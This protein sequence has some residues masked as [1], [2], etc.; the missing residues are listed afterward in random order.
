MYLKIVFYHRILLSNNLFGELSGMSEK[1]SERVGECFS[2]V[3]IM[4]FGEGICQVKKEGIT[5]ELQ[6]LLCNS[7]EL[8]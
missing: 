8:Q 7:W 3:V 2:Q 5:S 6:G 4:E 1:V